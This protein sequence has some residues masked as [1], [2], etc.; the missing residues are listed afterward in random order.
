[1][2]FIHK[3]ACYQLANL[4]PVGLLYLLHMH[5][6]EKLPNWNDAFDDKLR[7]KYHQQTVER[8]IETI[9]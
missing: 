3:Q 4:G 2:Y 5:L 7:P 8:L 1:M 6:A 9:C